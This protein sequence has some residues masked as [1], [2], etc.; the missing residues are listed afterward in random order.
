MRE[1]VETIVPYHLGLQHTRQFSNHVGPYGRIGQNKSFSIWR[2]SM[3]AVPE[4][5]HLF[6]FFIKAIDIFL[7]PIN[8]QPLK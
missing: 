1:I 4:T 5:N 7:N 6:N 8:C 2:F 3:N